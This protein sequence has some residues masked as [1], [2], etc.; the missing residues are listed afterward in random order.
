MDRILRQDSEKRAQKEIDAAVKEMGHG[1]IGAG[2]KGQHTQDNL[3][4][5]ASPKATNAPEAQTQGQVHDY[6]SG[7]SQ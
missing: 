7:V 3:K 1:Q 6:Y 4:H 5:G 2:A